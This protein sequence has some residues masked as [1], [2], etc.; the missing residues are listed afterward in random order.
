M[1]VVISNIFV[2]YFSQQSKYR[3][4]N[5]DQWCNVLE[6]SRSISTDLSNYDEDGA[7]KLSLHNDTQVLAVQSQHTI[8]FNNQNEVKTASN[9]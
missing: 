6:F 5:R 2:N 8:N 4:V 9:T 1:I 3:V 7:C